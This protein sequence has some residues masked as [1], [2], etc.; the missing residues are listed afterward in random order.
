VDASGQK[1]DGVNPYVLRYATG[2]L[3]PVHA[4]WSLTM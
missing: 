1:L 3:P 2:Q 4:F